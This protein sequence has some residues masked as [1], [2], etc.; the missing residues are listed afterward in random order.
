MKRTL[1]SVNVGDFPHPF[2]GILENARVFDSSCSPQAR[3]Y[4]IERD[5]GYY[6]KISPKG[7]LAHEAEMTRYFH[8]KGIAAR[9]L[10]Y[11]S[12]EQDF[13][14]TERLAGEDCT[15]AAYVAE[16]ERLCD[17][18]ATLLRTLHEE[19][20]ENCPVPDRTGVYLATVEQNYKKG[21][22]DPIYLPAA[23][24][25]MTAKEAWELVKAEGSHLRRDVL[26]HGD[27]CLPN[28]LLDGWRFSGFIDLD[29]AG[30]GDRH[31]DLFWGVWTL[32]FNLKTDRFAQRFLDAY[33]RDAVDNSLLELIGAAEAFG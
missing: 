17:L 32:E 1:T 8:K 16:P 21:M 30:V 27:Y 14:L 25:S 33:G 11:V 3:V 4:Y 29:N 12:E 22:F 13:L 6:L 28:I 7:T 5:G 2:R 19:S 23:L 9:V 26:L 20:C 24:R 18:L 15:H 31:I 10:D